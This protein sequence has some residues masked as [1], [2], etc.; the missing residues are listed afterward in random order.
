MDSKL[1]SL[2]SDSIL[3]ESKKGSQSPFKSELVDSHPKFESNKSHCDS[4]FFLLE[5]RVL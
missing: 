1:D 4:F 5:R 3:T 2:N